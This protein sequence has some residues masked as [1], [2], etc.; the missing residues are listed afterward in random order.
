MKVSLDQNLDEFNDDK[1]LEALGNA[2]LLLAQYSGNKARAIRQR[3]LG[4]INQALLSED[5]CNNIYQRIPSKFRQ[6]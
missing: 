5:S 3:K 6:W 1:E 4:F 2:Y